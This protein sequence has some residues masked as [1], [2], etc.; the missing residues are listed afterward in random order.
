MVKIKGRVLG[1]DDN[2]FLQDAEVTLSY[3]GYVSFFK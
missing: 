3:V 1:L 2:Q